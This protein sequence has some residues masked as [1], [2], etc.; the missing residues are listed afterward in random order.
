M[1]FCGLLGGVFEM[2]VIC[3][4]LATYVSHVLIECVGTIFYYVPNKC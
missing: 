3:I 4:G 1:Q 2:L